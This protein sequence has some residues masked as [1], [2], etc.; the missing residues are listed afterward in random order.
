MSRLPGWVGRTRTRNCQFEEPGL[1]NWPE[2]PFI[3]EHRR[4]VRRLHPDVDAKVW[5]DV[6]GGRAPP[7]QSVGAPWAALAAL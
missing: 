1:K 2:L 6:L 4:L 3:L 7:L 5:L